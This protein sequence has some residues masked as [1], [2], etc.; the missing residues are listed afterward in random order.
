[1]LVVD[2]QTAP[3]AREAFRKIADGEMTPRSLAVWVA[4]L[5]AE[6]RGEQIARTAHGQRG[7]C[8][9]GRCG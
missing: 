3:Y 8:T 6:A 5:P 7:G 2:E 1:M 4:S 9:R